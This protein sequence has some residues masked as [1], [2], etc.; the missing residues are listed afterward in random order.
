[1]YPEFLVTSHTLY[2]FFA[3]NFIIRQIL[4]YIESIIFAIR[5]IEIFA[6][7]WL[8]EITTRHILISTALTSINLYS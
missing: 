6:S 4:T 1:M 5:T 7:I 2:F 3:I 8:C